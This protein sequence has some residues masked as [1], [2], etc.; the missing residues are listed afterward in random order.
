MPLGFDPPHP[1]GMADFSDLLWD[2]FLVA[3]DILVRFGVDWVHSAGPPTGLLRC[4]QKQ[5]VVEIRL[6]DGGAGAT[7]RTWAQQSNRQERSGRKRSCRLCRRMVLVTS[8]LRRVPRRG[9]PVARFQIPHRW[10]LQDLG[11]GV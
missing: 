9:K 5:K 3:L 1:G 4:A 2:Q 7:L 10:P 11:L 8:R 6:A